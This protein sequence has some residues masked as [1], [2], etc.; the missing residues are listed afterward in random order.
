ML[1]KWDR[2]RDK[3]ATSAPF[4]EGIYKDINKVVIAGFYWEPGRK[5]EDSVREYLSFEFSPDV[6]ED[7][8]VVRIFEQN[9]KRDNIQDSAIRAFEL[10]SKA[11]GRLT[12]KVHSSW[13]WR[14]FYLRALINKELCQQ[15]GEL[16]GENLKAASAEL[17][18]LYHAEHAPSMPIKPP[19]IR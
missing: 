5:A 4:S 7:L 1:L 3:A 15:K 14:I 2:I 13:R 6:A 8:Q 16:Q 10:V 12:Q 19:E 9:H 11:E 18:R 17:T